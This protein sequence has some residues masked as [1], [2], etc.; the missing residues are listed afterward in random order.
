MNEPNDLAASS[1]LVETPNESL[2]GLDRRLCVLEERTKPAPKSFVKAITEWSGVATFLLAFLYTFPL[3]VWDRFI[4]DPIK[5]ERNLIVK[6]T[7]VDTEL[8]KT[9]QNLPP[10]QMFALELSMRAKKTALLL[11]NREL[12]KKKQGALSA[13]ETEL[14]AYQAGSVGDVEL[15]MQLYDSAFKKAHAENK[16]F[17]VA[18]IYRVQ[19]FFFAT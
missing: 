16:A 13:I 8:F 4:V 5:E 7:E 1:Q 15:A 19:A 12:I 17:L 18:D 10:D 6:L 2:S 3:G 9:S 14:L 11:Q